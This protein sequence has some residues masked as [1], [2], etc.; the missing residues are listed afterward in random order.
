MIGGYF[1]G[2]HGGLLL[3][4]P[5]MT[6]TLTLTMSLSMMTTKITMTVMMT[7]MM[8]VTL[9]VAQAMVKTWL[10]FMSKISLLA[11]QCCG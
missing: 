5:T 8:N 11:S 4:Y 2:V 10:I 9:C 6:L 3:T 7:T 1:A